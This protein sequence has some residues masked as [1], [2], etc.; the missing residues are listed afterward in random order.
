MG[1][2]I[3]VH[4]VYKCTPPNGN[5]LIGEV[6]LQ[7]GGIHDHGTGGKA[8]AGGKGKSRLPLPLD[9]VRGGLKL[10]RRVGQT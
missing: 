8:C 5:E 9:T 10:A 1:K 2:R 6:E 4:Q 7:S 3:I